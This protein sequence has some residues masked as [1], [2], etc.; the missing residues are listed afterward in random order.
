MGIRGLPPTALEGRLDT[1]PQYDYN[2]VLAHVLTQHTE[3]ATATIIQNKARYNLRLAEVTAVPDIT[4]T[5][6]VLN[7][8]SFGVNNRLVAGV[9]AMVPVPVW[10]RNLGGIQQAQSNLMRAIEE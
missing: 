3:V 6:T 1:L 9:Q 7:D 5:T 8:N 4:V 10:D 2:Q